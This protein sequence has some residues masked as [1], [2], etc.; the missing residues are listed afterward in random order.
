MVE[1][2]GEHTLVLHESDFRLDLTSSRYN[3][4]T[5]REALALLIRIALVQVAALPEEIRRSMGFGT[6]R[7]SFNAMAR[8]INDE[9]VDATW[10]E[11]VLEIDSTPT[12]AAATTYRGRD[13]VFAVR[14]P[15]PVEDFTIHRATT[16]DV[17]RGW[18][19]VTSGERSV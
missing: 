19:R 8:T 7:E 10:H 6:S 16:G 18:P 2:D 1:P 17:A 3:D 14:W 9:L 4:P 11:T 5:A 13:F 12:V 15:P